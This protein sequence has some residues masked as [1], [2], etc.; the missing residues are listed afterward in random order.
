[1]GI[2]IT[3]LSA[4]ALTVPN[5]VNGKT[6]LTCPFIGSPKDLELLT[7]PEVL[8]MSKTCALFF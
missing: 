6:G 1:M 8:E 5:T 7:I 3:D 2:R 4:R